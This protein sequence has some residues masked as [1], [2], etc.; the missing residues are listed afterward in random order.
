M[1]LGF[2]FDI[3]S[4]LAALVVIVVGVVVLVLLISDG[5]GGDDGGNG[6]TD[7]RSFLLPEV[8][9]LVL[10]Q[11]SQMQQAVDAGLATDDASLR[12]VLPD[13]VLQAAD[14][15]EG[16][17]ELGGSFSTNAESAGGLGAGP[18]KEQLD[19][20]GRILGYRTDLQRTTPAKEA[21]VTA[22]STSVSVYAT[23]EGAGL[24]FDDRVALARAADW[25]LSHD[26]LLEFEQEELSP[27]LPVDGLFWIRLSG[28]QQTEPDTQTLV[29]DDQI[30]F[31]V[32]QA[33]GFIGAVSQAP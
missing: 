11:V 13:L 4:K 24:S 14:A 31:R 21:N 22:I 20:W 15:P 25:Q 5:D 9:A 19:E 29:S 1:R 17:Q 2:N 16:L 27:D 6:T 10:Q 33:W 26:E 18:T 3:A 28:F 7:P 8:E 23:A 30:V 32:G 12:A